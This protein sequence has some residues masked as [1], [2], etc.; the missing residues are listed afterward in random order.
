[1]CPASNIP[2]SPLISEQHEAFLAPLRNSI[3]SSLEGN[4]SSQ[5]LP[6]DIPAQIEP[7]SPPPFRPQ[8][9]AS[10]TLPLPIPK[11]PEIRT[12]TA[13][14]V[15]NHNTKPSHSSKPSQQLQITSL[16][17]PQPQPA[18][19]VDDST[20]TLKSFRQIRPESPSPLEPPQ[21]PSSTVGVGPRPRGLSNASDTSQR[22]TVA[23][24]REAQSRS[25]TSSL[26]PDHASDGTPPG[27]MQLRPASPAGS[28]F[29]TPPRPTRQLPP[30]SFGRNSPTPSVGRG[31]TQSPAPTPGT[32]SQNH[33]P[34]AVR[35]PAPRT[36]SRL[37]NHRWA[38][39]TSS[40]DE[41]SSED[42]DEG[43]ATITKMTT[44][45]GGREQ[46]TVTQRGVNELGI[47]RRPPLRNATG[48]SSSSSGHGKAK[49][50]HG[51][52]H[53]RG[54]SQEQQWPT[55]SKS[56]LGHGGELFYNPT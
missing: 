19:Q 28:G 8:P 34:A 24:F 10:R 36:H 52:G 35:T 42:D 50:E 9:T 6:T 54:P 11:T 43:H 39:N 2:S 20:F 30:S 45:G 55:A 25:R 49:S 3:F 29:G 7:Y 5:S 12:S 26:I 27:N 32:R 56:E 47:G 18:P 37:S 23:A 48:G 16:T 41:T 33:S 13:I 21:F 4:D 38:Q 51:H 31:R 22:M 17:Q 40:E 46:T 44:H 53:S 15:F 1:M 14:K